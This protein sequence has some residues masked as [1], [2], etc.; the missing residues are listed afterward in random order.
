M[1]RDI[2][3]GNWKLIKGGMQARWG[4]LVGDHLG[5]ISG[6]RT[7]LAGE[8]QLAFG[9]IRA[10]PLRASLQTRHPSRSFSSAQA[11]VVN[12]PQTGPVLVGYFR[13]NH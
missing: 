11:T 5:V 10:K 9:I 8:R 7:Q 12:P 4:R 6:K 1:N 13:E 2:V 3:A